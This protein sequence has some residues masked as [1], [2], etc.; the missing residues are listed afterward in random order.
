MLSANRTQMLTE[1]TA[2]TLE[3]L[4]DERSDF[5]GQLETLSRKID[6]LDMERDILGGENKGLKEAIRSLEMGVDTTASNLADRDRLCEKLQ[7]DLEKV[8][9]EVQRLRQETQQ[10]LTSSMASL[11]ET[12]TLRNDLES[13]LTAKA[14]IQASLERS[15]AHEQSLKQDIEDLHRRLKDVKQASAD[16]EVKMMRLNKEKAQLEED[17]SGLYIGLE[18]KQEELELVRSFDSAFSAF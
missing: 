17:N 1:Y 10:H 11:A 12:N 3:Q 18:A 4:E 14:Q 15:H 8:T 7:N 2:Q 6:E 5:Q 16:L 13:A 9:A